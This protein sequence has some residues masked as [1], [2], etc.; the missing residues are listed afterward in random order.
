MA[1][2]ADYIKRIDN[3]TLGLTHL[4]AVTECNPAV[5]VNLLGERQIKSH[6]NR[7]PNQ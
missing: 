2:Y 4:S 3:V 1:K 5:T 6:K 7:R